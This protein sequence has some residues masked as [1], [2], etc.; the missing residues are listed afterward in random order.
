M[1]LVF[2]SWEVDSW[3]VASSVKYL[4]GNLTELR[5]QKLI[6]LRTVSVL[7]Y[8]FVSSFLPYRYGIYNICHWKT[9]LPSLSEVVIYKSTLL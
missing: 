9:Q 5:T 6:S 2:D 4:E 1:L 3:E 7:F 8:I